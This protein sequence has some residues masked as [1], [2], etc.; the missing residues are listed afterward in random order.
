[1]LEADHPAAPQVDRHQDLEV[2]CQ[3]VAF[4]ASVL[5]H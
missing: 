1:L 2:A 4:R 3:A 5:A